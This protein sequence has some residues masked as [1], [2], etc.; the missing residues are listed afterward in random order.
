MHR[1]V[2]SIAKITALLGGAV[3]VAVVA[4]TCMSIAGRW[5]GGF[6]HSDAA[7]AIGPLGRALQSLGPIRGD[8][9]LVEAGVAFAIMAFLP[10]C[11]I[12]RAHASVDV[13]TGT[14]PEGVQR[15]LA[16]AWEVV[17]AV[18]LAVI[19]WR[20]FVGMEAKARYGET[21]FM[22]QVPVWWGYAAVFAASVVAVIAA[23]YAVWMRALDLRAPRS[24]LVGT[25]DPDAVH[26]PASGG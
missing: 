20:L 8:F 19:S 4:V 9:E 14:L 22:L 1:L 2:Q 10:W 26:P 15:A 24:Q 21:T 23:L 25:G 7:E 18:V 11:Q 12:T 5:L 3:L 16:L 6:G 13:I 17:F